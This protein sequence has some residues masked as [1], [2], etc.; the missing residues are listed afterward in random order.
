[1]LNILVGRRAIPALLFIVF[2]AGEA[3]AQFDFVGSWAPLATEDGQN[4]SGPVDYLGL[5]LT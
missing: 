1:M 2:A 4:D 5:A 3:R